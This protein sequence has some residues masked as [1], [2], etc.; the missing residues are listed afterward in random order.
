MTDTATSNSEAAEN[1]KICGI[2]RPIAAMNDYPSSHWEDVHEII[3]EASIDA[4]FVARLVSENE[5][6]GVILS[7]IVSNIYNND[8]VVADVSGRNPNVMFELGMRMA[9]ERPVVIIID[10]DTPFSFDISPVKHLLYPRTLRFAD[11]KRFKAELSLAISGAVEA[12]GR[13]GYR[14]YLQQFGNIKVSK[15]EDQDIDIQEMAKSIID[16]QRNMSRLSNLTIRS[17]EEVIPKNLSQ[18]PSNVVLGETVRRGIGRT[19][20][21]ETISLIIE[22]YPNQEALKS[23]GSIEGV[24]GVNVAKINK[25]R[26]Q[27]TLVV[28]R[29][30]SVSHVYNHAVHKLQSLGYPI[31]MEEGSLD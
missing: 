26:S 16:I 13:R 11:I 24:A 8:I 31:L 17:F 6:G 23:L 5:A 14:G 28:T 7:D 1:Q 12:S 9:F 2:V 4:G 25:I 19:S 20:M 29:N 27:L 21:N 3:C 18:S 22:G 30:S 15:L 10:D